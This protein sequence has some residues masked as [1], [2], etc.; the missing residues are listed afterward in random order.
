M[1]QTPPVT[2]PFVTGLLAAATIYAILAVTLLTDRHLWPP[3]ESTRAYYL[4]W[5][6][7]GV[8]NVSLLAVAVLDWNAWLL[9]RPASFAV[10]LVL[11][12]LGAV[13]FV[14]SAAVMRS[15][16]TMGITG[17]LYTDGPYAYSRNPQ[18]VGMIVGLVGFLLLVNSPYVSVLVLAHVGWVLVLP[19][20]EEPHLATEYGEAYRTYAAETPR[21]VGRRT[22]RK[23][24][25]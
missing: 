21:F 5:L 14:R 20:A 16:E 24:R 19:R 6:S 10:G 18:Y 2:L 4:H 15:A 7:V 3:G 8:F 11:A 1:L 17:D 13:V 25:P 23:L 12:G 9:P 22:L